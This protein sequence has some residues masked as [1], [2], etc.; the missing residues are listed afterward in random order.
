MHHLCVK[1]NFL[2]YVVPTIIALYIYPSYMNYSL[3]YFGENNCNTRERQ[4]NFFKSRE[5]SL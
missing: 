4:K 5:M 3:I 1:L 2:R